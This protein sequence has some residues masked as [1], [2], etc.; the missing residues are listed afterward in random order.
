MQTDPNK[1]KKH[2]QKS[3]DK[4]DDNAVVQ[5]LMAE[6][7]ASEIEGDF[8]KIL[9]IGAGT[10][11]LTKLISQK[12]CFSK[13]S[14]ND[15]VEE[16][17]FFVKKYIPNSTFI[18]GDFRE[19]KFDEKFNLIVSNAVFQ[20]FEN[21]E[22]VLNYC[23]QLLSP[24]GIL[25]FSTFSPDNFKEFKEISGLSLKYT[26]L[27]ELKNILNQNF[28]IIKI[29]QFE[30]TMKFNKAMEILTHMKNTG[31]NSL[32]KT[33]WSITDVKS[34]CNTYLKQYPEF[35]LTYSPIIVIAKLK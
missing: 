8:E 3:M 24:R 26:S 25:A 7:L 32:A 18:S 19:I 5:K 10:G 14:A 21:T 33:K 30:Y 15:L 11:V 23:M 31:V 9:E 27:E 2:F 16:S 6:Q 34:F 12:C 35:N 29:T 17:E 4:Y 1:I 22:N 28:E 13:Y 20:W